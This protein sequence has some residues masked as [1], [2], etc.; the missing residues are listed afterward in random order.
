MSVAH[1]YRSNFAISFA[2]HAALIRGFSSLLA[3]FVDAATIIAVSVITGVLYHH[4]VYHNASVIADYF[5]VGVLVAWLYLLPKILR[6]EYDVAHYI[7]F[8]DYPIHSIHIWNLAFA[9]LIALAFLTKTGEAY[10]RGWIVMFYGVGMAAVVL[11]H[12]LLARAFKTGHQKGI[13]ATRRLFLVGSVA[14]VRDFMRQYRPEDSGLEIVGTAF[15]PVAQDSSEIPEGLQNSLQDAVSYARALGPDDI[16]IVTPWSH[17]KVIDECIEAFVTVPAS[18][19]LGPEH[20]LDR[21]EHVSIEKIGS[22]ASLHLLRPPLSLSS[23]ITKRLFD[24]VIS[25][26]A[27]IL[28]MPFFVLVAVLIKLDSPG[29]IFFLQRRYGFNQQMFRIVKFRTM[30]TTEDGED[31]QQATENDWRITRVGRLLR[32]WNIDELPQLI[33]VL[34]G[35][36]SLVGPR[37]HALAHD[38]SWSQKIARY[39]KRHN[40]RPGISGWAQVNGFRGI[41]KDDDECSQR[42]ACDLY[43]I[44]N[45]SIWLDIRILF[46]TVFSSKAYRNAF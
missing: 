20:I 23:I 26:V 16:F 13:L 31:V 32:R 6:R 38:E 2:R 8:K 42:I 5:Q 40:M 21:F 34:L 9:C 4:I 18:I 28:L 29:P 45:W 22:V 33:N 43:Y 27:L 39:A 7:N 30:S 12:A 36:M 10:S 11:V 46:L 41:V 35:D 44:D 19:H 24:I 15:L 25:T 14:N 37:P 1:H 17:Q 3:G